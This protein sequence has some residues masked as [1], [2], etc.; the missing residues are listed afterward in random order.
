MLDHLGRE[1]DPQ[2]IEAARR[3][4]DDQ[5][6]VT[7]LVP[8]TGRSAAG[9]LVTPDRALQVSA[10]WACIR[11]LTQTTGKLSWNLRRESDAGTTIQQ[12]H[13]V[14]Y[15]LRYR[16]SSEWSSFQ[17]RETMLYWALRWGNGYA[18]IER[19][20][21]GRPLALWPLSPARTTT[22]RDLDTDELF[23]RYSGSWG[24]TVDLPA[25]DV[26]HLRGLGEGPVGLN[27][28]A[29]AADSI[30]WARAV[31]LF[32]AS[33][34][35]QSANP[36]GVVQVK[37]PLSPEGMAELRADFM[38]LYGGP[39]GA[40]KVVFLDAEMTYQPISVEPEKAQYVETNQFLITEICRW[41]GVPPHKVYDLSRATFT[42]IEH[43]GLEVEEDSI[44][45]WTIRF[46]DEAD[47]KLLGQNRRSLYS[48]IEVR[49]L[50]MADMR[51]RME[52]AQGMRNVG[53]LNVNEIRRAEGLNDIGPDGEK[54]TMQS[55][56][57][58]L[59][60]IGEDLEPSEPQQSQLEPQEEEEEDPEKVAEMN[61]RAGRIEKIL[62]IEFHADT[63]S[64][65]HAP[66]LAAT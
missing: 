1:I 33:F 58:T 21:A 57:T 25:D 16:P 27:V 3:T 18:E 53:A 29:Y 34:F 32:G 60:K 10:V 4:R 31:Q 54:Y 30:G 15:L 35:R 44:E 11:F 41:F 23:Y 8:Y 43:Q 24:G 28:L 9:V 46:Q 64:R 56:M 62:G 20:N 42:N 66:A 39:S 51:T 38:K 7:Q 59:E 55:G 13:P 12:S 37:R 19:D 22:M 63:K 49:E 65:S 61:R 47:Y 36:S 17:F 45:P 5:Y 26:F 14:H 40:N 6:P 50:A 48:K 52:F 2:I